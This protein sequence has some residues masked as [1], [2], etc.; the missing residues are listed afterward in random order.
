MSTIEEKFN[1]VVDLVDAIESE[2]APKPRR[3]DRAVV[4]WWFKP[5]NARRFHQAVV[6]ACRG[7]RWLAQQRARGQDYGPATAEAHAGLAALGDLLLGRGRPDVL[8]VGDLLADVYGNHEW[9]ALVRS[10]RSL[11]DPP[12]RSART[13]GEDE[14][15]E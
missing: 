5:G 3:L 14:G 4:A 2:A 15:N 7:R 8:A 10:V 9:A 12:G 1:E 13:R 11:D 6:T